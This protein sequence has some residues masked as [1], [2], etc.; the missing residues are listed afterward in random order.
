MRLGASSGCKSLTTFFSPFNTQDKVTDSH[1]LVG[2]QKPKEALIVEGVWKVILDACPVGRAFVYDDVVRNVQVV[3]GFDGMSDRS[4][5]RY[6][7][8][9]YEP[10]L[11]IRLKRGVYV[12]R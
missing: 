9:L 2:V 3:D 10:G 4:I 7:R 1:E 5:S 11:L 8:S 12:R 6:V